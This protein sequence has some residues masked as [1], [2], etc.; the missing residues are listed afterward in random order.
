MST[1]TH[2]SL[3]FALSGG[4]PYRMS[5]TSRTR[6]TSREVQA[7]GDC[8]TKAICGVAFGILARSRT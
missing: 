2:L 7:S 6:L 1:D 8:C 5:R 4:V 3:F